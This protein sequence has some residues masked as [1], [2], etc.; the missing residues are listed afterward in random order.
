MMNMP[1]TNRTAKTTECRIALAC[2]AFLLAGCTTSPGSA[3]V[4]NGTTVEK[5][6]VVTVFLDTNT[7]QEHAYTISVVQAGNVVES[8]TS[9][10]PADFPFHS[11]VMSPSVEGA[12]AVVRIQENGAELGSKTVQPQNCPSGEV[13]V[14]ITATD[15]AASITAK[16]S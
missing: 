5:A 9:N 6:Y 3:P 8:R 7:K 14:T 11:A 13:A 2:I 16:C 10:P 15:A 12:D 1:K 4:V